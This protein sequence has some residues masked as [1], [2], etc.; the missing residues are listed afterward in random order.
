MNTY[1]VGYGLLASQETHS[2]F[3]VQEGLDGVIVVEALEQQPQHGDLSGGGRGVEGR[4][5]SV[6]APLD[7]GRDAVTVPAQQHLDAVLLAADRSSAK[8]THERLKGTLKST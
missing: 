7:V 3:V 1:F 5:P 6:V 4:Q 2:P 8:E